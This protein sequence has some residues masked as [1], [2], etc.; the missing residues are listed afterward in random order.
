MPKVTVFLATVLGAL[1]MCAGAHAEAVV[2]GPSDLVAS[3]GSAIEWWGGAPA[4]CAT[5]EL[6]RGAVSPG[7][8]A[9]AEP[10][11]KPESACGIEVKEGEE[12]CWLAETMRHEVGHLR[13]LGHSTDPHS[14][15]YPTGDVD[16]PLCQAERLAEYEGWL[17]RA[18]ARCRRHARSEC[19]ATV[20]GIRAET[21][22]R[23]R[24]LAEAPPESY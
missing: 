20:R 7:E 14:V 22:K 9:F 4:D 13:G 23:R 8:M 16:K 2:S 10:P 6:R 1:S 18:R 12:G 5:V 19:R 21:V 24:T 15:M 17:T 11:Y 3:Y